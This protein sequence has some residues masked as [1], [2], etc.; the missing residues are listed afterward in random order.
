MVKVLGDAA[1]NRQ[2]VMNSLFRVRSLIVSGQVHLRNLAKEVDALQ[3]S[4]R[5]MK[6]N[7]EEIDIRIGELETDLETTIGKLGELV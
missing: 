2:E 7:F 1:P 4:M 3:K 6:P 5:A